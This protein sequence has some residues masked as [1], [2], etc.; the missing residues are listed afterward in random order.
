MTKDYYIL[1]IFKLLNLDPEDPENDHKKDD[2]QSK[3]VLQLINLIEEYKNLDH[4]QSFS[5]RCGSSFH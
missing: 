5:H 3:T 1:R 2:L 4:H